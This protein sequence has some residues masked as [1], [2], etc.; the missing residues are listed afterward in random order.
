LIEAAPEGLGVDKVVEADEQVDAVTE[1]EQ[2]LVLS[3]ALPEVKDQS[4]GLSRML[5]EHLASPGKILG[6]VV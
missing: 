3:F 4:L 1:L 5:L 6:I 2:A